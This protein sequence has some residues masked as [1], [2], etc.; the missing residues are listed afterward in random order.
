LKQASPQR[1]WSTAISKAAICNAIATAP[2]R[3]IAIDS[4]VNNS[5][6]SFKIPSEVCPQKLK[7]AHGL[8]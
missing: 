7:P 1:K 6:Q 2:L 8:D 5:L 4:S 3:S